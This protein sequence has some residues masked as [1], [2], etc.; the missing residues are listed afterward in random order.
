MSAVL[1]VERSISAASWLWAGAGRSTLGGASPSGD[2]TGGVAGA[3]CAAADKANAHVA[4]AGVSHQT[5]LAI[6]PPTPTQPV[7]PAGSVSLTDRT[8]VCNGPVELDSVTV[9]ITAAASRRNRDAVHLGEGCTG[10]IGQLTVTQYVAD[11][12]RGFRV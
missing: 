1:I 12:V 8:W 9:T 7:G 5:L 6:L 10:R 3:G 11:G 4:A 2:G